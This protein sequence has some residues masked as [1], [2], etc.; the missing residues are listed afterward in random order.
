MWLTDTVLLD[1]R[2]MAQA[3][4]AAIASGV[5][6]IQLMENAGRAV[7]RAIMQ[8]WAPRRAVVLCG[9]GNNGGDGYVIARH[10]AEAG[11]QVRVAGLGGEPRTADARHHAALWHGDRV[12]FEPRVLEGCELVVD[13]IFGAGL[14]RPP[15]G[16]AAAMMEAINRRDVP[17]CAVDVPS[18]V[19]GSSG[20]TPGI[21]VRADLTVTFFRKK[22]GHL[23]LPGKTLCGTVELVDIGIPAAVLEQIPAQCYENDPVMWGAMYP[24][25]QA[26]DHK[27]ARGHVLVYGGGRMTGAAR[28]TARAA[29]RVGAGLV[30]VASSATAW[31]I[32]ATALT[33]IMTLPY[34]TLEQALALLADERRNTL[35]VGPGHGVTD[36]T[37]C[38]VLA[39]LATQRPVVL[40]ADALTVFQ[41]DPHTLF[42]AIQGPCVLTP[43]EGEF[44]RL[45]RCAGNKLERARS[46]A[47]RSGA[48]VLLKGPDTVVA[49]PDGRAM[50]NGAAPPTLATGGTGD[51]LTGLIGGL[52]AQGMPAFE[53]ACAATWLHARAA[54]RCGYGLIADDL[55]DALPQVLNQLAAQLGVH[56]I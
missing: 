39:A 56:P 11:W 48:V 15:E 3:D 34:D 17:V 45:F 36:E 23:L 14:V 52:L 20:Q 40:D 28:L 27:Y 19:D 10:L 50:I 26:S 53:A 55:P 51:V 24:W 22:P 4:A 38:I 35:I 32:Y 13:A 54:R 43:H 12:S 9:P 25:P 44:A 18:G 30:T 49:A 31:P 47:V 41:A 8:R 33:S 5:S 21:A 46:A 7:A 16:D 6:G 29:Q 37:R 42:D 2:Q 1:T